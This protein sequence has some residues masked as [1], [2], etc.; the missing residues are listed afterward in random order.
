MPNRKTF[1]PSERYDHSGR[2]VE[3][4]QENDLKPDIGEDAPGIDTSDA[5]APA[6]MDGE[7]R[8]S[9]GPRKTGSRGGKPPAGH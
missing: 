3:H 8:S 2:P 6:R 9:L 1:D 7:D 5:P 4:A